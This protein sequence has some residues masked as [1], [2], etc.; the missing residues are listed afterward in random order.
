MRTDEMKF[1]KPSDWDGSPPIYAYNA[2]GSQDAYILE[3][4]VLMI[5]A[6]V[7]AYYEKLN[8]PDPVVVETAWRTSEIQV[9]KD[10]LDAIMFENPDALPGTETQW[11]AYGVALQRWKEGAE[12][13]PD[14]A[15]RP[16]RPA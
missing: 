13:W 14:S 2:D 6:E 12:G 1:Y 8:T 4:G 9:V 11:K 7:D 15:H 10:N 5:D 16:A 3:G